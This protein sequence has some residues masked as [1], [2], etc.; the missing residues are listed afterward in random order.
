MELEN[1]TQLA[2]SLLYTIC[3]GKNTSMFLITCLDTRKLEGITQQYKENNGPPPPR[4]PRFFFV[5]LRI[6]LYCPRI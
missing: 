4:R 6:P 2:L 5:F 3:H 1:K